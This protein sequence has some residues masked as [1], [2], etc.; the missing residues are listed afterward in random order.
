MKKGLTIQ[1]MNMKRANKITL[2]MK[3]TRITTTLEIRSLENL[4]RKKLRG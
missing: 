4:V 2:N 1:R 3:R